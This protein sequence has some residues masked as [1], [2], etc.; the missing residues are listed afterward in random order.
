VLVQRRQRS[1]S[2]PPQM[3]DLWVF[4]FLLPSA[5]RHDP[6]KLRLVV[7]QI[8]AHFDFSRVGRITADEVEWL[9]VL[10]REI[11]L[12]LCFRIGL[13]SFR[14]QLGTVLDSIV[15]EEKYFSV[16]ERQSNTRRTFS[17]YSLSE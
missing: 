16:D 7:G 10:R 2:L 6:L 1:V 4:D 3:H 12:L 13:A 14:I 15:L 5:L 11:E 17:I 8:K 9:E